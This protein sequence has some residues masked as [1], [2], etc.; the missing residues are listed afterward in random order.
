MNSYKNLSK[1]SIALIGLVLAILSFTGYTIVRVDDS[2]Y[3]PPYKEIDPTDTFSLRTYILSI[4]ADSLANKFPYGKYLDY[5]NYDNIITIK[6]DLNTLNTLFTGDSSLN[7]QI[8]SDA[9]TDSLMNRLSVK[10]DN[11]KADSLIYLL[12]WAE[13]FKNY[14]EVD[15]LNEPLFNAIYIYWMGFISNK[16]SNYSSENNKIRFDFK[17]RFLVA[18]CNEKH[19]YVN[20][21]VTSIDKFFYNLLGNQW[22]HLFKAS[23]NQAT[24]LQKIVT[25][26]IFIFTLISYAL[27]FRFLF[28]K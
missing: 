18:K 5:A 26:V 28:K 23:W 6:K 15:P 10:Y 21:R 1:L 14:A 4:S 7:Q 24:T 25:A 3:I 17:Y 8:L 16:L 20:V 9:L 19:S 27:F 13:R 2:A 12:Q 11:Y 22:T